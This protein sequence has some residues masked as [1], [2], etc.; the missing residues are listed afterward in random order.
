[1]IPFQ[2]PVLREEWNRSSTTRAPLPQWKVSVWRQVCNAP[3]GLAITWSTSCLLPSTG[4]AKALPLLMKIWQEELGRAASCQSWP[5]WPSG[6]ELC[7]Q[8]TSTHAFEQNTSRHLPALL[9]AF[10]AALLGVL[11]WCP[12]H[13]CPKPPT[14]TSFLFFWGFPHN[15]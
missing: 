10:W 9:V 13:L 6:G 8:S 2:E 12:L 4:A 14:F 11:L 15:Q 3:V 7:L 5:S 1:M